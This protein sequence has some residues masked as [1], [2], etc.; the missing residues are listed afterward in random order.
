MLTFKDIRTLTTRKNL[1]ISQDEIS[2]KYYCITVI[3]KR[4]DQRKIKNGNY[5]LDNI[6]LMLLAEL[7][8]DLIK[9]FRYSKTMF[10]YQ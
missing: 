1:E 2:F 3:L 9:M 4:I 10:K 7:V 8:K 5:K 6:T